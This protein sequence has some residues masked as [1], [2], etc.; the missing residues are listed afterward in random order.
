MSEYLG[1]KYRENGQILTTLKAKLLERRDLAL[2]PI[3]D[4]FENIQAQRLF[5]Y[6]GNDDFQPE[7]LT[8]AK[9]ICGSPERAELCDWLQLG[10]LVETTSKYKLDTKCFGIDQ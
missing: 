1:A 4:Q 6:A 7:S 2:R 8:C 3:R 10:H 5:K 9:I